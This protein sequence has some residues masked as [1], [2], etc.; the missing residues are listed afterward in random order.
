MVAARLRTY[1]DGNLPMRIL[2]ASICALIL[3][4]P[5]A[6]AVDL[7]VHVLGVGVGA[8]INKH[9]VG[10]GAHVGHVGAGAGV[11]E[12][13]VAAEGHAGHVIGT[14]ASVGDRGVHTGAHVGS[15]GA[16][17]GLDRHGV[18]VGTHAGSARADAGVQEHCDH[19]DDHGHCI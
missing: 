8:H 19:R 14:G 15:V 9:G 10:A 3:A 4:V 17:G 18:G 2:T 7:G 11:G 16:G 5:A 6:H 12:H 13:G 1:S